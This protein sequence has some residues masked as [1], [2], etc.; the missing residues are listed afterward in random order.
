VRLYIGLRNEADDNRN[1]RNEHCCANHD[2]QENFVRPCSG[3]LRA[4]V[5]LRADEKHEY[6]QDG[7]T[8]V[9]NPPGSC[10]RGNFGKLSW[11]L[12]SA[13]GRGTTTLCLEIV[14]RLVSSTRRN[15]NVK[16]TSV[17]YRVLK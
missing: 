5:S 1:E 9:Q 15:A 4:A 8:H 7:K 13:A 3:L 2:P 17:E 12:E 16:R 14:I 10:R 11:A 6:G